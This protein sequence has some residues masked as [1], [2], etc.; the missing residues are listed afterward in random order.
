M[1]ERS[2]VYVATDFGRTKTRPAAATGW[3]SGH[4]LNNGSLILSPFIRGNRV[5]GGVDPK[6]ARTY[7]FN[8]QTGEPDPSA[9]FEEAALYG[10]LCHALDIDYAGRE[11]CPALMR[12]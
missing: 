6:T 3:G 10:A 1:W 7:G 9:A 5:Y 12:V 8:R 4:D 11:D 2:L